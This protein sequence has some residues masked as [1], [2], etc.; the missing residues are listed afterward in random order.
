MTTPLSIVR[1][2][3]G[4]VVQVPGTVSGVPTPTTTV[5]KSPGLSDDPQSYVKGMVTFT[6]GALL[7]ESKKVTSYDGAGEL[8]TEAFSV[9]PTPGDTFTIANQQY[10]F[11]FG[12]GNGTGGVFVR[13][14]SLTL[15]GSLYPGFLQDASG[16]SD[17]N[18]PEIY[19]RP[20]NGEVLELKRYIA[21]KVS[22]P[23]VGGLEVYQCQAV[24]TAPLITETVTQTVLTDISCVAG[25][26]TKTFTTYTWTFLDGDFVSC[27]I[28]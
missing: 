23:Q 13:V 26:L 3:P 18:P 10:G 9:A 19:I 21:T 24:E 2:Y 22:P 11:N 12:G 8:T 5:F 20:P 4:K 14:T 25:V 6:S 1:M 15:V 28:T 27:V 16:N 7:G 17:I